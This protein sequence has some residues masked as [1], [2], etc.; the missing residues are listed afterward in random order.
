MK[1]FKIKCF[2]KVNLCLRVIKKVNKDYHLIKSFI[3]F[4]DISDTITLSIRKSLKD[5]IIF[6]GRFKNGININTNTISKTLF[7]LRKKRLLGNYYFDINIKKNIPH[8][9]GL[10]GSSSN[11]ANLINFLKYK[12]FLKIS[13]REKTKI[14]RKVGFD[15]PIFFNNKNCFLTGKGE[16]ILKLKKNLKLNLLIVYPNLICSTKKIYKTNKKISSNIKWNYQKMNSN[17]KLINFLIKENNDLEHAAVKL[18]P[19][20]KSLINIISNQQGCHFSRITG[21]GSACVGIFS[22]MKAANLAKKRIKSKFPKFWCVA[23]KTI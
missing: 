14:G 6:S 21:S 19:K 17:K 16:K 4:C 7:L 11:A 2:C 5:K 10:G 18:Y 23:S 15:V 8:G 1:K 12:K 13:D 22:N 3:T 9:S 20:I